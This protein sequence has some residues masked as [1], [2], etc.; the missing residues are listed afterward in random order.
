M[1]CRAFD[2]RYSIL[3]FTFFAGDKLIDGTSNKVFE[4]THILH[5]ALRMEFWGYTNEVPLRGLTAD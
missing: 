5:Q 4:F 3:V 1:L 2:K